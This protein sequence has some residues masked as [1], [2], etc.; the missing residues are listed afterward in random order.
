MC[1]STSCLQELLEQLNQKEEEEKKKRKEKGRRMVIEEVDSGG[2]GSEGEE[3]SKVTQEK[4][5]KVTQE[6]ESK[7]TQT[8]DMISND[9]SVSRCDR[10]GKG[11]NSVGTDNKEESRVNLESKNNR[12]V[13]EK[14]VHSENVKDVKHSSGEGKQIKVENESKTLED[15]VESE[16]RTSTDQSV[17]QTDNTVVD[18]SSTQKQNDK[19]VECAESSIEPAME[20]EVHLRPVFYQSALPT[21]VAELREAGNNLFRSGQYDQAIEKYKTA[22][23]KLSKGMLNGYIYLGVACG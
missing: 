2:S 14:E 11:D 5:S 1:H 22:I 7:V 15:N 4:K 21:D 9:E 13:C 20:G 18:N 23:A 10:T 3:E 16:S 19:A 8:K 17:I 6:Q 12:T